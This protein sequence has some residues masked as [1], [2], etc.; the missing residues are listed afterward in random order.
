MQALERL[1][2]NKGS[3]RSSSAL[4]RGLAFNGHADTEDTEDAEAENEVTEAGKALSEE[5]A[6]AGRSASVPNEEAREG[7]KERERERESQ[8]SGICR[9]GMAR[10]QPD[11]DIGVT[12]GLVEEVAEVGS[13]QTNAGQEAESK[14]GMENAA[15]AKKQGDGDAASAA[16]AQFTTQFTCFTS[17]KVHILTRLGGGSLILLILA[18]KTGSITQQLPHAF[19][20]RFN[21]AE[22]VTIT[23][24]RTETSKS[25]QD[26][27]RTHRVV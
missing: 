11:R 18:E 26:T 3:P 2:S 24:S 19:Y 23:S 25:A 21:P 13:V 7:G 14:E 20:S 6:E 8:D 22:E 12:R 27:V 4:S 16:G 10:E 1:F 17:T 5:T 15:A 9:R